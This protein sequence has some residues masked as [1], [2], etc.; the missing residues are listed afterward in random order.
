M[1]LLLLNFIVVYVI[2]YAELFCSEPENARETTK[3]ENRIRNRI[4]TAS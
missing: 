2:S 4:E 1:A 3:N